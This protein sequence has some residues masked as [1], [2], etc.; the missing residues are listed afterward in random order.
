MN[1][2]PP[3]RPLAA[4]V[5]L[6]LL[7]SGCSR[8]PVAPE[9]VRSVKL[10]QVQ[11]HGTQPQ[12]VYAADI[13]ARTETHLGFRV[14]GKLLQRNV[15]LGQTVQAGQ[16][17]AQLDAQD[18]AL[19]AQA[20]QAQVQAAQT[21]RDLAQADWQRFSALQAE[22]FIS[23]VELDRRRASLQAAQA[24]LQQAQAQATV[25]G[26]Q[27]GYTRLRTEAAGVVTGV[28][29][30]PGQVVAAGT[31]VVTVALDGPRDAVFAVP[32]D[33]RGQ[34][35]LGQAVQVQPWG[36]DRMLP[37]TVREVAASADPVT[38]TFL[39]KVALPAPAP[40][41]GATVQVHVPATAGV[42]DDAA[43]AVLL[44]PTSAVWQQTR[45]G[46]A[47]WLFDADS[48]TVRAQPVELGA[49]Q[50]NAFIVRSGLTPGQQVVAAGTHVLAQGQKVTVYQGKSQSQSAGA[51]P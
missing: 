28:H 13:R 21:Q 48:S 40:A 41:L 20:A 45:G 50:G 34:L 24:Q 30:E 46:A 29:A 36:S 43:G 31:P 33:A 42:A 32:E 1:F 38:R 49:V 11:L 39:A 14:A 3:L 15:E 35:A 44:L 51:Q 37:G 25:Q 2:L 18:Y 8:Q 7:A 6:C 16:V 5:F 12:R 10:L 9:P 27:S 26:N 22:G 23:P 17:L 47:V 19:G 4:A